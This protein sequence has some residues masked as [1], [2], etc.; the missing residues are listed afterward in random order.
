M[1][2]R[3]MPFYNIEDDFLDYYEISEERE[4]QYMKEMYPRTTE[5]I[6][7]IIEQECDVYEYEG[8]ILFDSY[9]DKLA[10]M[11]IVEKVYD[12][13]MLEKEIKGNCDNYPDEKWLKDIIMLMLLMEMYKRRKE[14]RDR[15]NIYRKYYF[16]GRY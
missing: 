7:R 11:R 16:D 5:N 8:S 3:Y 6:Q 9:P 14:R 12:R 15:V 13:I 2:Y 1:D 4:L 10:M